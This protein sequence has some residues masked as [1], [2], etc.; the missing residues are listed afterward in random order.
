MN[1][2]CIISISCLL[3]GLP[4]I[5]VPLQVPTNIPG[6]VRY[7]WV[8]NSFGGGGAN[9]DKHV[10]NNT[11]GLFVDKSGYAFAPCDYGDEGCTSLGA[12]KAGDLFGVMQGPVCRN[13]ATVA[14]A[15]FVY[16][17]GRFSP[18]GWVYQGSGIQQYVRDE[19]ANDSHDTPHPARA[20][21]PGN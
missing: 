6:T 15:R 4:A 2:I 17:G 5:A 16:A 1:K 7:S 9:F 12:Y 13:N 8:G 20:D 21:N 3:C 10:G 14:D 18:S 19:S 11:G